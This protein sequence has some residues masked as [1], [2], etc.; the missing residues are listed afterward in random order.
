MSK[1]KFNK[2]NITASIANTAYFGTKRL[3]G[4]AKASNLKYIF[5]AIRP[6]I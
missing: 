6:A 5:I 2:P 4:L 3:Y 1:V